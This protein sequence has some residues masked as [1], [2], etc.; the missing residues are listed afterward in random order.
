MST[1][2]SWAIIIVL[3]VVAIVIFGVVY[4]YEIIYKPTQQVTNSVRGRASPFPI[5]T[6]PISNAT[7]NQGPSGQLNPDDIPGY[8][9]NPGA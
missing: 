7:A 8:V 5:N 6:Y 2:I 4:Y 1:T 9:P 3:I